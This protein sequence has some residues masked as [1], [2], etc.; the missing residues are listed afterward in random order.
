MA[1]TGGSDLYISPLLTRSSSDYG[2]PIGA[3]DRADTGSERH[4]RRRQTGKEDTD[5]RRARGD[6]W[7]RNLDVAGRFVLHFDDPHP[8][9]RKASLERPPDGDAAFRNGVYLLHSPAE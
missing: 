5:C 2:G 1:S 3:T 7:T 4:V 8:R 9:R 6:N